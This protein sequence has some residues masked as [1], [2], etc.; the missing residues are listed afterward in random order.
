MEPLSTE[1]ISQLLLASSLS[2]TRPL[3]GLIK[4]LVKEGIVDRDELKAFLEPMLV[5]DGFPAVTKSMLEPIWKSLLA[6]ISSAQATHDGKG[7]DIG[8]CG[9]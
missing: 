9:R 3:L 7:D 2:A 8:S 4:F 5:V 1:E 6:Q